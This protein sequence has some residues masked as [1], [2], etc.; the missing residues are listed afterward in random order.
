ML[1]CNLINVDDSIVIADC[2]VGTQ[3]EKRLGKVDLFGRCNLQKTVQQPL[4]WKS[5][6]QIYEMILRYVILIKW[7]LDSTRITRC[8]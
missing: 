7:M 1:K 3:D 6:T 8:P 5:E 4:R 2:D